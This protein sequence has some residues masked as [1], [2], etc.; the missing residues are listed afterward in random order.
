LSEAECW[1]KL[2][3]GHRSILKK[4]RDIGNSEYINRD[5]SFLDSGRFSEA[6]LAITNPS[7][8]RL[9]YLYALYQEGH[10]D[11]C[12]L[13]YHGDVIGSA[14]FLKYGN[15]VQYCGAKRFTDKEIPVHHLILWEAIAKYREEHYQ[16]MDLGVFSYHSQL[17]YIASEKAN[18]V[19]VFKRG[20]GGR[21]VPFV[22]GEKYFDRTYFEREYSDR[23]SRYGETI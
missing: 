14:V 17:N 3:K 20:F 1:K 23:V 21:V 16:F 7:E 5:N 4:Y 19:A 22:I 2:S 13:I 10:I 9:Q 18:S 8:S 15:A 11:I 12:N 6:M